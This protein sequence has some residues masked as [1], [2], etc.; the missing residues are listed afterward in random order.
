MTG[1][2]P[3]AERLFSIFRSLVAID[4]ESG[5]E[6]E[7]ADFI[8][9]LFSRIGLDCVEDGA[10][11]A[12][13]GQSGN[14]LV[15][16]DGSGALASEQHFILNAH[17][18]TVAPGKS[19]KLVEDADR[20]SSD[21]ETVLGADDKAGLAAIL[22]SVE[23]LVETGSDM[24]PA[25]LVL[26]VQEEPGLIGAGN[27]DLTAV[28]GKWGYVL[29]GAGPLGGI[30]TEAPTQDKVRVVVRGRSAHAGVEPEKGVNAIACA[31]RAI[32]DLDLGRLDEATTANIGIIAGGRAVN[33]VPDEVVV[34][35]E[36]RS[37][38]EA[39]LDQVREKVIRSFEERAAESGCLLEVESR[40]SFRHFKIDPGSPVVARIRRAMEVCGIEP[41]EKTSG[42]GSDANVLNERG[43]SMVTLDI[44]IVD[45]HS[46]SESIRKDDL[47]KL[48]CL[49]TE[50]LASGG[51]V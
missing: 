10:G 7:V 42:G 18:D 33:I 27:L 11:E 15:K 51:G 50:L 19:V 46:K 22:A 34:E 32:A 31:S 30:V 44:G 5:S 16:V 48:G 21:G 29:D 4:S 2:R 9:S 28:D 3:D 8:K 20:F 45:A 41:R 23:K 35:G 49:V 17:L 38:D 39:R 43:Y 14:L 40:R 13:G 36:I 24:R 47:F 26:T 6:G 1:A 37:L 25:D 12:T